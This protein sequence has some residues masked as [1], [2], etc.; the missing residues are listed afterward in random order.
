MTSTR[1]QIQWQGAEW[2]EIHAIWWGRG[3]KSLMLRTSPSSDETAI[4]VKEINSIKEK[5]LGFAWGSIKAT[6]QE[7]HRAP[8]YDHANLV[9]SVWKYI[10]F[11][12]PYCQAAAWKTVFLGSSPKP[13]G[14]PFIRSLMGQSTVWIRNS[15]WYHPHDTVF[16]R[17]T[18]YTVYKSEWFTKA[19]TNILEKHQGQGTWST[20][21][22]PVQSSSAGGM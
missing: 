17:Y 18:R 21:G 4:L 2:R 9:E 7:R 3:L 15:A 19:F 14:G 8:D 11:R 5:N 12:I 22:L 16:Y 10:T 1:Y 6:S 20:L 13:Y